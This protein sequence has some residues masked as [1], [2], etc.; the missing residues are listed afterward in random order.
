MP[1]KKQACLFHFLHSK[2][3]DG[4]KFWDYLRLKDQG[5]ALF[6]CFFVLI[7]Q[8]SDFQRLELPNG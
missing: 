3:Q 4:K 2:Q 8:P 6:V 7:S 5:E 1:D